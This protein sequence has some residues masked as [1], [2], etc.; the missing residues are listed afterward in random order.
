MVEEFH[1]GTLVVAE[2]ICVFGDLAVEGGAPAEVPR[3]RSLVGLELF[4]EAGLVVEECCGFASH[5]FVGF[6]E[7]VGD[8]E[9]GWDRGDVLCDGGPVY[10][11]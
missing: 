6:V 7:V 2:G 10:C 3:Y 5:G 8:L 1:Q 4:G 11:D 9:D